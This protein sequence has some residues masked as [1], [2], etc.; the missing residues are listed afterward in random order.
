M[1]TVKQNEKKAARIM[2]S[3]KGVRG[4][5]TEVVVLGDW[6]CRTITFAQ[7]HHQRVR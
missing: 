1:E 6:F 2:V 3:L 7:N 4:D 5:A